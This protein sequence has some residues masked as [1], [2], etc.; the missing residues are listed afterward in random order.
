MPII[1]MTGDAMNDATPP[2]PE[3]LPPTAQL[4]LF[5][6]TPHPPLGIAEQPPA[7]I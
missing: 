2:R 1:N 6:G 7:W 4:R 5:S 3:P